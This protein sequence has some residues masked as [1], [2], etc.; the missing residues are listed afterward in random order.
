MLLIIF[1]DDMVYTSSMNAIQLGYRKSHGHIQHSTNFLSANKGVELKLN[2]ITLLIFLCGFVHPYTFVAVGEMFVGEL[3]LLPIGFIILMMN[4][5]A[6]GLNSKVFRLLLLGVILTLSGYMLSDLIRQTD[7]SKFLRGWGRIAFLLT[8]LIFFAVIVGQRRQNF[9]WYASGYAVGHI[10]FGLIHGIGFSGWK[11][12][13]ADAVGIFILCLSPFL[14]SRLL[15][16]LLGINA[17][18]SVIF[19][20]RAEPVIFMIVAI[21]IWMRRS[22]P[23]A[24]SWNAAFKKLIVPITIGA[25]LI[26]YIMVASSDQYGERREHSNLGRSLSFTLG[27][28]AILQSPIIG[29]GSWSDNKEFSQIQRNEMAKAMGNKNRG[30]YINYGFSPHSQILQSW[31]EGGILGAGFFLI[32]GF[33]IIKKF[34]TVLLLRPLDVYYGLFAHLLIS[35]FWHFFMS[36]FLGEHRIQI[37]LTMGVLIFIDLESKGRI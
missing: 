11:I 35:G 34:K 25:C 15:V 26:G 8:D 20:S 28:Q 17:V 29:V 36:P 9:W 7:Q 4:R 37:M 10:F 1:L 24:L 14:R 31:Y 6:T 5:G 2:L 3:V 12:T 19:D 27:I 32:F 18:I 22:N 16:V 13:Y 33:L 30:S 21:F 23:R